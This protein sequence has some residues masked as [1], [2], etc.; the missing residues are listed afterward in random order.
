MK[1]YYFIPIFLLLSLTLFA[2]KG[3]IITGRITG[4]GPEGLSGVTVTEKNTNNRVQT[5]AT[6]N[7]TITL[8]RDNSSLVFSYVGYDNKEQPVGTLSAVDVQLTSGQRAL[9]EVV[10]T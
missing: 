6:G 1:L 8:S 4:Q 7:Y 5:D 10:V 3:K 2:Q 9:D